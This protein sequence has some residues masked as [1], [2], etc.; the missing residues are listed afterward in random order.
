MCQQRNNSSSIMKNHSNIVSEKE[1]DN[2]PE[3]K[4]KVGPRRL[5]SDREF[6]IAIRKKFNKKTQKGGSMN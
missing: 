2:F 5:W 1:N 6:K 4:F 3:A